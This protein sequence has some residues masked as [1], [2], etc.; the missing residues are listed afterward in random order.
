MYVISKKNYFYKKGRLK[1][2]IDMVSAG[3]SLP[4]QIIYLWLKKNLG[5]EQVV[6]RD[7][8]Y[9]GLEFDI[10]VRNLGLVIEYGDYTYHNYKDDVKKKDIDKVKYAKEHGLKLL[11]IFNDGKTELAYMTNDLIVYNRSKDKYLLRQVLVLVSQYIEE[12]C[13]VFIEPNTMDE[14]VLAQAI[15]ATYNSKYIDSFGKKYSNL[16]SFWDTEKNMGIK[17]EKI[18][19]TCPFEFVFKCNKCNRYFKSTIRKFISDSRCRCCGHNL[20]IEE[21]TVIDL[22]MMEG[23]HENIE[24]FII[25]GEETQCTYNDILY[26]TLVTAIHVGRVEG[27][28]QNK[29]IKN[30]V[31][32]RNAE[33]YTIIGAYG[34]YLFEERARQYNMLMETLVV[35]DIDFSSI[36]VKVKQEHYKFE[37]VRNSVFISLENEIKNQFELFGDGP[38][39]EQAMAF[40]LDVI[41]YSDSVVNVV[42][43][44]NEIDRLQLAYQ[45]YSSHKNLTKNM[46]MLG[47]GHLA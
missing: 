35:L 29:I 46:F 12:K 24:A 11:R 9:D 19:I 31:D 32:I 40:E 1:E 21:E 4:E 22:D 17:P 26:T 30:L 13:G 27:L 36:K 3:T 6:N 28:L 15:S 20:R 42:T 7:T 25:N 8:S 37:K 18:G 43:S 23:M 16:I 45:N 34:T 14:N 39:Q 10:S 44:L 41:D 47:L 2:E 33:K 38:K 5:E